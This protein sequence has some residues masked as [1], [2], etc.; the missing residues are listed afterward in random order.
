MTVYLD[1]VKEIRD[2]LGLVGVIIDD[3][4]ILHIVLQGLPLNMIHFVLQCEPVNEL[5]LA[6]N[7]MF[8]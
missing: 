7:F 6:R 5:F 8:C 1:R 2:K 4:E 3:E